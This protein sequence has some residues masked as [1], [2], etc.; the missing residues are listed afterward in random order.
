VAFGLTVVPSM[1]IAAP[2]EQRTGQ[3]TQK[4]PELSESEGAGRGGITAVFG[5]VVVSSLLIAAPEERLT[6]RRGPFLEGMGDSGRLS[7]PF[8]V[9]QAALSPSRLVETGEP[10]AS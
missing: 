8:S 3:R 9:Q 6:R 4:V 1:L 2:E 5:S 7:P 10:P